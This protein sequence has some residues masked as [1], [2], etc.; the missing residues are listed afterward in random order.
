MAEREGAGDLP[1]TL[2]L[3]NPELAYDIW[4]LWAATGRRHLP[5]ELVAEP[6]VMLSDILQIEGLYKALSEA[7]NG[8]KDN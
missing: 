8:N 4:V 5:S 6:V 2:S 1:P 3:S 7:Q